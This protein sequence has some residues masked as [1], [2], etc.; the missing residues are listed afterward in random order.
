MFIIISILISLLEIKDATKSKKIMIF[1]CM[2]LIL[3]L[4]V[5][6]YIKQDDILSIE[7][8]INRIKGL[9]NGTN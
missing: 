7:E 4:S 3:I 6:L 8:I 2:L 9:I 1:I 5:V